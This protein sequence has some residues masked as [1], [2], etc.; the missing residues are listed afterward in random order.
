MSDNMT[1]LFVLIVVIMC[2][3]YW[4]SKHGGSYTDDLPLS[5]GTYR[6]GEDLDPGK[7]DI[8]AVSGTGDICIRERGNDVWNDPFKLGADNPATASRYRNMTLKAHDIL[9]INGKVKILLSPP[10][11]FTDGEGAELTLGTYQF[12]VDIPPAKYDLK[13]VGGDGQFYFY[14]PKAEA[15]STFQDM[16]PDGESKTDLYL[17]VLCEDGARIQVDGTIKL[18]LTKSKKQRGWLYKILDQVN[19]DP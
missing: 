8:V 19:A 15:F 1:L 7:C 11:A 3:V 12:G 5:P 13:A 17:N 14:E 4:R 18:K 16:N 6:V 2:I 10:T 9:E